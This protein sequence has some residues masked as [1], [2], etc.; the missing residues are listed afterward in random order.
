MPET[1]GSEVD[2]LPVRHVDPDGGTLR[3]LNRIAAVL[4][5]EAGAAPQAP[6]RLDIVVNSPNRIFV[7]GRGIDAELGGRVRVTG[8][9]DD[10][11]P[12]GA[13]TLIRGRLSVL[14][15]RL[16]LTEGRISLTGSLD[17][18]IDLTAQVNGD[19]IVAYVE[20]TGRAS[21][22]SLELSSSPELPQDEILARVLFGKSISS[23]SPLQIANLATA[24]ASLASGGSGRRPF[25]AAT[26]GRGR[27]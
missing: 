20:L 3:T 13:F 14:G 24:A 27:R 8:P 21:D 9:L 1:I 25:R 26:P 4:P 6:L 12:V 16:E 10:L 17:P 19:E 18:V 15:K 5:H 22:L 11:Q 2:L 23:L 7:R